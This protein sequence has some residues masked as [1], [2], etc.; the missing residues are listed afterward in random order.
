M[1]ARPVVW[2]L[3]HDLGRSGVPIA[4]LRLLRWQTRQDRVDVHVIA[5]AAGPQQRAME[6]AAQSV[7]TLGPGT[8]RSPAAIAA[9]AA[10]EAGHAD[11]GERLAAAW[12]R[13]RLRHLPRP[14]VVLVQGA[15][16]WDLLRRAESLTAGARVVLHLHE[17]TVALSRCLPRSAWTDLLERPDQIL[18]V[19]APVATMAN[20]ISTPRTPIRIVPGSVDRTDISRSAFPGEQRSHVCSIGPAGWRKGTDRAEAVAHELARRAPE[21]SSH[22]FGAGPGPGWEWAH[23][24]V[25]PL[26]HHHESEDVWAD[27]PGGAVLLVP[28]REDPLPLVALEAGARGIP[29]VAATGG[30]LDDLLASNRGWLVDGFDLGAMTDAILHACGDIEDAAA[31]SRHLRDVVHAKHRTDIVG[32][33][34]FESLLG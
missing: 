22:W 23:G 4:L 16:A 1:N 28:S 3:V 13:H 12:C 15:G 5:G 25:P 33:V 10:T 24:P 7:T 17:L 20:D 9:L 31:R 11:L 21:L 34:W 2:V 18:A 6:G 19:S 30:G 26:A 32:P 14:D 8:G 27:L 29:V